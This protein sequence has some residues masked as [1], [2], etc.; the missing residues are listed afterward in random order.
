M[1]PNSELYDWRDRSDIKGMLPANASS[2][3]WCNGNKT[4]MQETCVF[5]TISAMLILFNYP[6]KM[7]S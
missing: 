3:R 1:A 6:K 7:P 4:G 5:Q 2:L